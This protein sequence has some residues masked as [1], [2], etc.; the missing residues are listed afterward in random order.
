MLQAVQ[1]Y[2]I[3]FVSVNRPRVLP[4]VTDVV[5]AAG[6][7]IE[8][9]VLDGLQ[10]GNPQLGKISDLLQRYPFR[11]SNGRYAPALDR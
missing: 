11:L 9:A 10:G 8:I 7:G 4:D 1:L 2:Q 6:Q 5:N 3:A